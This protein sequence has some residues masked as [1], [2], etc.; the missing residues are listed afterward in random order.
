MSN[1]E[2]KRE[3][4]SGAVLN[5]N[6]KELQQ[7][8][9]ARQKILQQKQL[10]ADVEELKDCVLEMRGDIKALLEISRTLLTHMEGDRK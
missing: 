1:P 6:D 7:Y 4:S 5:T 9:A 2:L 3:K 10:R 8:R